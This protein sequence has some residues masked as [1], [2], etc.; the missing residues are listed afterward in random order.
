VK[1]V[2]RRRGEWHNHHG[3]GLGVGDTADDDAHRH[4]G[5]FDA[6]LAAVYSG[7]DE[8]PVAPT[9]GDGPQGAMTLG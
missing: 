8:D 6:R 5:R 3:G 1:A 4:A 9:H 7:V 2:H